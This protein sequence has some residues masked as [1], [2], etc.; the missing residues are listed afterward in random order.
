[1]MIVQTYANP[2]IGF[3]S[4]LAAKQ[5][6]YQ[7]NPLNSGFKMTNQ[8]KSWAR[9]TPTRLLPSA[10]KPLLPANVA[11]DVAHLRPSLSSQS[12]SRPTW[13]AN[14]QAG[15]LSPESYD[16]LAP[17]A[18]EGYGHR[19]GEFD[20]AV[21]TI[22]NS[23]HPFY[24][25]HAGSAGQ[26]IW[27]R[28][29]L[30]K[31]FADMNGFMGLNL[32]GS[33][34]TEYTKLFFK[35]LY[36]TGLQDIYFTRPSGATS[37]PADPKGSPA[38]MDISESLFKTQAEMCNELA[39][40]MQQEAKTQAFMDR[41]AATD[42]NAFEVVL[43]RE[44]QAIKELHEKRREILALKVDFLKAE[45]GIYPGEPIRLDVEVSVSRRTVVQM[46][47]NRFAIARLKHAKKI[48][49]RQLAIANAWHRELIMR[50]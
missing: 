34:Q 17:F 41:L 2:M 16:K 39:H 44:S 31:Y 25:P 33:P 19:L 32:A 12:D 11:N 49:E 37:F 23:I 45:C 36:A 28:T 8:P 24:R 9:V 29:P 15:W 22:A 10:G 50:L 14:E 21:K 43:M 18:S 20:Q 46:Q 1:M 48:T 35:H 27:N 26:I 38:M 4:S 40:A 3:E 7:Y 47:L 42:E 13:G 5:M 30:S 6:Q